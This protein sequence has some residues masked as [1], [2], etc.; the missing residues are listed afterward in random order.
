MFAQMKR[1]RELEAATFHKGPAAYWKG[2]ADVFVL[3]M[4]PQAD[5][6]LGE[7]AQRLRELYLAQDYQAVA[8]LFDYALAQ[9]M[10]RDATGMFGPQRQAAA[11]DFQEHLQLSED[12]LNLIVRYAPERTE[13]LRKL[14]RSLLTTTAPQN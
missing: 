3:E 10:T 1:I 2:V 11:L 12:T 4:P 7:T 6:D 5:I 14:Y 9:F 13:E 8:E